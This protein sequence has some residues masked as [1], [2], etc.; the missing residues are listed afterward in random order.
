MSVSSS[1]R[2]GNDYSGAGGLAISAKGRFVAFGSSASNLVPGDT[3]GFEDVF[4]HDR[5]SGRTERVSVSTTGKQGNNLSMSP[6][7]SANGRFVTFNSDA[8]NLV[9]GDAN[10][11]IDVFIRDRKLGTTELISISSSGQQ[12]NGFNSGGAISADGRFVAFDTQAD[13]LV[14]GDTN[15]HNDVFVRDRLKGTTERVSIS[16]QGVQGNDLSDDAA[17][18]ANGRFVVFQ[19]YATNLVKGDTNGT[20]DIFVRDR[21]LGTTERVSVSSGGVQADRASDRGSIT[22][23]GRFVAFGS[24]ARNLVPGDA[25]GATDI[26]VRTR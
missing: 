1:G 8:S 10:G 25:N 18:S 19:S 20:V 14:P 4:V 17:L 11:T 13:N 22:D 26:F 9:P 3:N 12:G 5:R 2:Q 16:S 24:D 21:D 15:G 7:I 23:G 6:S